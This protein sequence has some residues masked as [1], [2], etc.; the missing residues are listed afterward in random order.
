[1]SVVVYTQT[2]TYHISLTCVI[3]SEVVGPATDLGPI[4]Y[5]CDV[6]IGLDTCDKVNQC[7]RDEVS[8][9]YLSV[10]FKLQC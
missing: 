2:N 10:Y 3:H 7:G 5:N 1:L 8:N 6:Q 9:S 4:C